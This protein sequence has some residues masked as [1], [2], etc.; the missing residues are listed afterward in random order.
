MQ[1]SKYQSVLFRKRLYTFFITSS[2]LIQVGCL[3]TSKSGK[4]QTANLVTPS[5]IPA[6]VP[7]QLDPF[8]D[9]VINEK[10][11]ENFH[12]VT[13]G[14]FRSGRPQKTGIEILGKF[15]FKSVLSIETY[16][17]DLKGAENERDWTSAANI[18]FFHV[19][20]SGLLKPKKEQVLEALKILTETKNQPILVHC[21]KGSDRTGI[22]IAAYRIKFEGWDIARATQDM[23]NFGHSH[24]LSWWDDILYDL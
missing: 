21:E 8:K 11:I 5:A 12:R 3:P 15:G 22:T 16:G 2:T 18:K 20:M 6:P 13:S 4:K 10:E 1:Q 9:L 19:P 14:I 7:T 23:Y 24:W 17:V